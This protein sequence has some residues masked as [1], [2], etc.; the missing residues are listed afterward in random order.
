M[1]TSPE[2][3]V[4][5][6]LTSSGPC[7]A[8]MLTSSWAALDL[9]LAGTKSVMIAYMADVYTPEEFG[10]KQPIFGMVSWN[11]PSTSTHAIHTSGHSTHWSLPG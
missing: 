10:Q 4:A 2:P 8:L 5:L 9:L 11:H 7:V 3:Y 1:H 6:M